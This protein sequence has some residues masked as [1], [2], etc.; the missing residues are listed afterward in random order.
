M[1]VV[2]M[3]PPQAESVIQEAYWM[4]ADAGFLLTDRAFAGADTLA[5]AFALS[6]LRAGYD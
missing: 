4:G 2:S 1:T 3:G 6:R 5:T